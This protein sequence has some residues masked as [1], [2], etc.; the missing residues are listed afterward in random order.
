MNI[1]SGIK[2]ISRYMTSGASNQ[3]DSVQTGSRIQDDF[4]IP[5]SRLRKLSN[6]ASR[7]IGNALQTLSECFT[8]LKNS[9]L[10]SRSEPSIMQTE[11]MSFMEGV[12]A[13]ASAPP[14]SGIDVSSL[15][16]KDI[17]EQIKFLKLE[18]AKPEQKEAVNSA[19]TELVKH[20]IEQGTGKEFAS[21]AITNQITEELEA[22]GRNPGGLLRGSGVGTL[23]FSEFAKE[24]GKDSI[25]RLK[26]KI[27]E[28]SKHES[29]NIPGDYV[30]GDRLTRDQKLLETHIDDVMHEVCRSDKYMP[31]ALKDVLR[32][33]VKAGGDEGK[34][35]LSGTLL[36]RLITPELRFSLERGDKN[37]DAAR[38]I[39]NTIQTIGNAAGNG[40]D[41]VVIGNKQP[42]LAFLDDVASQ[43][44]VRYNEFVDRLMA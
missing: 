30:K 27:S 31:D 17:S 32:D 34:V 18:Y 43:S 36:L 15:K 4:N 24:M 25:V 10:S 22:P 19:I 13:V 35:A 8:S 1:S 16:S 5:E 20:H 40:K 11:T 28:I 7:M 26:S 6:E 14:K 21:A 37:H 23:V 12:Q 39:I 3:K 33:I 41:A 29:M 2:T 44:L 42:H 38:T 9:I